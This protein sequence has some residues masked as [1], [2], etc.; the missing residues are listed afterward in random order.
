MT[1]PNTVESFRD[2]LSIQNWDLTLDNVND[3]FKDFHMKL[4]GAVSRPWMTPHIVKQIKLRNKIFER[5]KDNQKMKIFKS[6][7]SNL[8]IG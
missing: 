8:E 5:K 7:L 3:S 2:D 1:I 6:Y 4:E